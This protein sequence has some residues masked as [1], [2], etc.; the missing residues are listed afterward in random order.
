MEQKKTDA[1]GGA[2]DGGNVIGFERPADFYFRTAQRLFRSGDVPGACVNA[3]TC[4]RMEPKS[5]EYRL[6]LARILAEARQA[7]EAMHILFHL[8]REDA[9]E[10]AECFCCLG[11]C[12][13]LNRELQK[14]E[15][16]FA[17]SLQLAPNGPRAPEMLEFLLFCS[18]NRRSHLSAL[19]NPAEKSARQAVFRAKKLLRS[20]EYCRAAE[21]LEAVPAQQAEDANVRSTLARAWFET[22][23][24]EE[25]I[26][27]LRAVLTSDPHNVEA[28]SQLAVFLKKSG[29]DEEAEA[30]VPDLLGAACGNQKEFLE[31]AKALLEL[32][33]Y[34]EAY[35]YL[36]AHEADSWDTKMRLYEATAAYNSGR[37]TEALRI[38]SDVAKLDPDC[39]MAEY[40]LAFINEAE[41]GTHE[42]KPLF[43]SL[44]L[45]PEEVARRTAYLDRC[46][47]SKNPKFEEM[48]G[49]DEEFRKMMR[50]ALAHED[51]GLQLA[52]SFL[53]AGFEDEE[54]EA[55]LRR[56]LLEKK[57]SD[58]IKNEVLVLLHSM[59]AKPPYTAFLGGETV[60]VRVDARNPLKQTSEDKLKE[61]VRI[62]RQAAQRI[63]APEAAANEAVRILT[64]LIECPKTR[65]LFAP[66]GALAAAALWTGAY[67][68][69]VSLSCEDAAKACGAS[70]RLVRD[71]TDDIVRALLAETSGEE[72]Y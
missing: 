16:C 42:S 21:T 31:I 57:Q 25:A 2:S 11:T 58:F 40:G 59:R 46:L 26:R 48:W 62:V 47:R 43:E 71:L 52:A 27:L 63:G 53:I 34:D 5:V 18:Q 35:R 65:R 55:V 49:I 56:F 64:K 37:R 4:V 6:F 30:L 12:F 68:S 8:L 24:K 7:P 17:L 14:A 20:R 66:I 45:P 1:S 22:G 36:R 38:F 23:R 39:A 3:R 50:W 70:S 10:D 44:C 61:A 69:A 15:E 72:W 67:E 29:L 9:G 51:E 32:R 19:E 33:Q 60:E 41:E 28:L 13:L 54:A